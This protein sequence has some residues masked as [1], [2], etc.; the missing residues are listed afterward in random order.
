MKGYID[1]AVSILTLITLASGLYFAI[2]RF[3][4]RRERFTFLSIAVSAKPVCARGSLVLVSLC[5][6]LENKGDRRINT[7]RK[8]L[9]DSNLYN[10]GFDVCA[11]AGT[12]KVRP[13]PVACEPL[14]FDWYSLTPMRA[15]LSLVPEEILISEVDD[16]EQI[17]YL[18]EFQD[19]KT[20]YKEVD[21]WLE[22]HESY[23]PTVPIWLSPGTYAAKAF[24]LGPE[25]KCGEEEY[26]S[27]LTIFSVEPS[28]SSSTP[29]SSSRA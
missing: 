1:L 29:S 9:R 17:N 11:H 3:G 20:A 23:D 21:C 6:H 12:L 24:F 25:T 26:W 15:S 22:P 19:P 10:D 18:S 14:L 16:L 4:L 28:A 27:S 2:L 7:R 8:R 13:I 5:V